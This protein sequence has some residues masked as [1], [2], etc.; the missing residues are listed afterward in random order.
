MAC[1]NPD[2]R[3]SLAAAAVLPAELLDQQAGQVQA[4]PPDRAPAPATAAQAI[5]TECD[6]KLE[7]YRAALDAG[8]DPAVVTG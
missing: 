4:Q 7:P 8:A 3:G 1:R 2:G 6:A 5:I